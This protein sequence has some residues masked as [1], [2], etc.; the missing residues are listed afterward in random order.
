MS[1][2]PWSRDWEKQAVW[3]NKRLDE[4]NRLSTEKG[5]IRKVNRISNNE[6]WKN[7]GCIILVPTFGVG[8]LCCVISSM[9]QR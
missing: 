3:I 7:I 8:V 2:K 5:S 9:R 1:I 4:D 6:F